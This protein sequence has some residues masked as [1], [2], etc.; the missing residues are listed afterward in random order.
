VIAQ[1]IST[2]P[3]IAASWYHRKIS[4][5]L[6]WLKMVT[7]M[8]FN[9]LRRDVRLK[10]EGVRTSRAEQ[11]NRSIFALKALTDFWLSSRARGGRTV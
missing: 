2:R 9:Q 4:A 10:V 3:T 11:N 5:T 7:G 1:S 6:R 8:P